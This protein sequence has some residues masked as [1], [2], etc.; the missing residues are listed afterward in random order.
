MDS[1][2]CHP[3][4]QGALATDGRAQMLTRSYITGARLKVFSPSAWYAVPFFS[5]LRL[6]ASH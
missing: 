4:S 1:P 2:F 6:L 3:C 5:T